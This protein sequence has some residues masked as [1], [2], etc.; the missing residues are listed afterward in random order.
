MAGVIDLKGRMIRK[1][2]Q[3]RRTTQ[4]LVYVESKQHE[5]I[6]ALSALTGTKP[7]AKKQSTLSEFIRVQCKEHCPDAHIH[8]RDATW[9]MPL[10]T[11]WTQ[12]GAS[13]VVV[14]QNLLPHMRVDRGYQEAIDAILATQAWTGAGSHAMWSNVK[15]LVDLGW[16]LPETYEQPMKD[17]PGGAR[18]GSHLVSAEPAKQSMGG[19]VFSNED[20][21]MVVGS[22]PR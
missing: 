21:M 16:K 20:D 18:V 6:R 8:V 17:W 9:S 7:E 4:T 22:T 12:T 13:M 15:R 1:K 11:R 2:N 19:V 3:D 14:L 5:V 10:T